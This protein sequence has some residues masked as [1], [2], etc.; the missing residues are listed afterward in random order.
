MRSFL[1][2]FIVDKRF[3]SVDGSSSFRKRHS[4]LHTYS[5]WKVVDGEGARLRCENLEAR[6]DRAS[7]CR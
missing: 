4:E 2:F 7:L 1:G 5:S 3:T 6:S